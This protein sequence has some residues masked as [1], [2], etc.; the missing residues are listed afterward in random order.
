MACPF[1]VLVTP[2]GV[3]AA[4]AAGVIAHHEVEVSD[5]RFAL[6][7]LALIAPHILYHYIWNNARQWHSMFK[8]Y[9]VF[10]FSA[11]AII[12]KGVQL[13]AWWQWFRVVPEKNYI[14]VAAVCAAFAAVVNALVTYK[15][16][17]V[18]V[19]YGFK[20]GHHVPWV[21][22]F[23]FSCVRHPQ[24]IGSI[25]GWVAIA[26]MCSSVYWREAS[27]LLLVQLAAYIYTGSMETAGD[28][29]LS[30]E[31]E[32]FRK[33]PMSVSTSMDAAE[34]ESTSS[35][36]MSVEDDRAFGDK[37]TRLGTST[38]T[39]SPVKSRKKREQSSSP[40][41]SSEVTPKGTPKSMKASAAGKK[42]FR[43]S[44]TPGG[45]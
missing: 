25:I 35:D 34:T 14:Y 40:A 30:G 22:T 27:G 29:I 12:L 9:S 43:R 31:N 36:A 1:S 20:L 44:A 37:D 8:T 15:L 41:S 24:Y 11:I 45:K 4:I 5:P 33:A 17:T 19:Y 6:S 26:I 38:S 7:V 39:R 13:L 42:N 16:G 32:A 21:R 18:G 10:A 3:A 28:N 2:A 23:P